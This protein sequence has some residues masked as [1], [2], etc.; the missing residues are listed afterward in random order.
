M[1]VVPEAVLGKTRRPGQVRDTERTAR[2]QHLVR[3]DLGA[4][5]EQCGDRRIIRSHLAYGIHVH[6]YS[7]IF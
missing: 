1:D 2:V 6:F 7:S 3:A 5:L 4:D